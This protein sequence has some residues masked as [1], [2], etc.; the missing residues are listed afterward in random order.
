M[1]SKSTEKKTSLEP[2]EI[3]CALGLFITDA[4]IDDL[5]KDNTGQK[6][7]DWSAKDGLAL[8]GKIKPLDSKFKTM[9]KSAGEE[10]KDK[11]KRT[12]LVAN[13]VAGFSG[14]K[15]VREFMSK[16]GTNVKTATAVYMTGATW[17]SEVDKFRMKDKGKGF[18][19]NSSDLVVQAGPKKF[20]GISLKK[21]PDKNKPDPT[22]INKAFSTFLEGT[23]PKNIRA[24]NNLNKVR[25]D[26]FANMVRKAH[27]DEI[28]NIRGIDEL[29]NEEIWNY[30]L[31]KPNS[32]DKVALINLKGF[33]DKDKP[34]EISDVVGTVRESTVYEKPKGRLGLKDYINKDLSKSDNKLFT[35]FNEII[36]DNAEF[37]AN[38]LIDMVLK[39]RLN[40][41]LEAKNIKDYN[42]EFGLV[43]GYADY[44]PNSKDPTKDKLTLSP[45]KFIPLHTVLCGLSN[46]AGNNKPYKIVHDKK[47]QEAANA[48]KVFYQLSRDGVP[49]LDLQLR[50]KGDFKSMPQFF[51]T[52]TDEFQKQMDELCLVQRPGRVDINSLLNRTLMAH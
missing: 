19:Y 17:P 12:D 36:Q 25:Q 50:Y 45:A 11:K 49:I 31:E 46:L 3:F 32:N 1:A 43:T 39:V 29:S 42:F 5:C 33:N 34:I 10:F 44:K 37:F 21:K 6:L 28:I 14:A 27:K 41:K 4:E 22:I 9:I 7:L 2:S 26:Y 48:A 51:A 16:T 38:K 23:D 52:I 8:S 47:K 35:G 30:K 18:D 24:I 20:F 13:I 40:V 15:G